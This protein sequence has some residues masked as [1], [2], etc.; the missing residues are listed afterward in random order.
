MPFR[1]IAIAAAA[2]VVC[3]A[4]L[5][6]FV[7][8]SLT[9]ASR[10]WFTAVARTAML[11]MVAVAAGLA[12]HRFGWWS[13]YVGRAW[14]LFFVEYGV[15][16]IGEIIKRARPDAQFASEICVVVAN[17]A[18]I[19]AYLLMAR[20]LRAAGLEYY[21]SPAKKI[22]VTAIALGVAIALCYAPIVEALQSVRSN[23]GA[24]VSPLADVITFVLVAPLLLTTFALRGGQLFWM[25]AFLTTGT[26]GWMVNQGSGTILRLLGGGDDVVRTGR[27]TGFAMAC[28][29]I[30]AAAFTQWLAAQRALRGAA[31][32]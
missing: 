8:P 14:T 5:Y 22:A 12:A 6:L 27:M 17:L 25:F 18:G 19:G 3:V 2:G 29:L 32:A 24:L 26:M 30:A 15:L 28:F 11:A 23:P 13:E 21:G 31:H 9:E 10:F 4:L 16:T 7:F 1:P 20:S